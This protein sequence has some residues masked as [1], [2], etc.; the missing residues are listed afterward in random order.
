MAEKRQGSLPGLGSPRGRGAIGTGKEGLQNQ[1]V[2]THGFNPSTW[3]V[4]AGRCLSLRASWCTEWVSGQAAVSTLTWVLE[5]ELGPFGRVVS[6]LFMAELPMAEP[7]D[8]LSYSNTW[9]LWNNG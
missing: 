8:S 2:V 1:L 6:T 9:V 3:E 4:E 5:V 7:A